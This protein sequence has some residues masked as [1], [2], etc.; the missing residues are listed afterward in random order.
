[1]A[2]PEAE[3]VAGSV[4]GC[5]K[6]FALPPPALVRQQNSWDIPATMRAPDRKREKMRAVRPIAISVAAAIAIAVMAMAPLRCAATEASA[7]SL[8]R[9]DIAQTS[10]GGPDMPSAEPTPPAPSPPPP[11][12]APAPSRSDRL[13]FIPPIYDKPQQQ[14][15]QS[16][17]GGPRGAIAFTA[18]GSWSTFWK[19]SSEAEAQADVAK[20]CAAMGH[21]SCEVASFS[22]QQCVALATFIGSY[23]RR[24]W[25]LSF[26]AGGGTYPEAQNAAMARC[27]ADERTRG[28]CQPR[29]AACADGR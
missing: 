18:D 14:P 27:N 29:T 5:L 12:R 8:R 28:R 1:L 2:E 23:S 19:M 10:L 3:L 15:E 9:F 22:G 6:S 17:P 11:P 26:T 24:R 21:G 16:S 25:L 7:D 20:R 4:A 13:D